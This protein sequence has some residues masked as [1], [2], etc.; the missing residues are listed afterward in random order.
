MCDGK[1]RRGERGG[2]VAR[3]VK[4]D[5]NCVKK[6]KKTDLKREGK[7]KTTR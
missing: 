2:K 1:R 3:S 7:S 6:E 4:I 5:I